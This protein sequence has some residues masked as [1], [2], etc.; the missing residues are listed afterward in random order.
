MFPFSFK[1]FLTSK[2]VI[3][4][5]RAKTAFKFPKLDSE[6]SVKKIIKV[7]VVSNPPLK[8][9]PSKKTILYI[10]FAC[11]SLRAYLMFDNFIGLISNVYSSK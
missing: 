1:Y 5:K 4:P 11:S 9:I 8:P 6:P 3:K 2:E 10:S 7:I